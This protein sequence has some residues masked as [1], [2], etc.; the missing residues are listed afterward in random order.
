LTGR[1]RNAKHPLAL[2]TG[3]PAPDENVRTLHGALRAS[4]LAGGSLKGTIADLWELSTSRHANVPFLGTRAVSSD[5]K[6]GGYEWMTYGAA[7]AERCAIASGLKKLGVKPGDRVGLYSVNCARWMLVEGAITRLACVSVPLYD[8]LGPQVVE[9]ISN[10][11]ELVAVA[12]HPAVLS[13]LL[14]SL[15]A[16]PT[17][18][19]VVVFSPADAPLPQLAGV[20]VSRCGEPCAHIAHIASASD[21]VAGRRRCAGPRVAI[22]SVSPC[23]IRH[24]DNLLHLRSAAGWG[25]TLHPLTRDIARHDGQP[26]G[27][28]VDALQPRVQRRLDGG[29]P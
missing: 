16:C 10:H 21:C 29:G 6:P 20:K 22:D 11:A 7:G 13:V 12:C 26:E 4:C 14:Q 5:G 17:V 27:C 28:A 23:A 25:C 3:F 9:Y 18:K 1:R 2:V 8:T 24:C 19:L 15:P